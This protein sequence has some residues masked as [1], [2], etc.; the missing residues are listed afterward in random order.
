MATIRNLGSFIPKGS[1]E[2]ADVQ[3]VVCEYKA[4][5]TAP[6]YTE[7]DSDGN[8][9]GKVVRAYTKDTPANKG[10]INEPS[11]AASSSED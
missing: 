8:Y 4:N 2:P 9:V 3:G 10:H 1:V 6:G 11:I 5:S 7:K